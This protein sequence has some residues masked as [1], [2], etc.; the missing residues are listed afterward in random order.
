M[1]FQQSYLRN[2]GV[3]APNNNELSVSQLDDAGIEE[4]KAD[5]YALRDQI[6]SYASIV[7]GL[8]DDLNNAPIHQA[9]YYFNPESVSITGGTIDGVAIGGSTASTG[10]FTDITNGNAAALIKT[11]VSLTNGAGAAVGTILNAPVAGNPTKW[12][13]I[14]DNGTTRYI[15]SW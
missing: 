12:V 10:R 14:N 11:S 7:S 15:P 6:N 3:L 9:G 5:L 1:F 4:I 8:I 13:A 2:G